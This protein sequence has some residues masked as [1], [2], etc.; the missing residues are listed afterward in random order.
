MVSEEIRQES[1][2]KS[3]GISFVT[4]VQL[5]TSVVSLIGGVISYFYIQ[6]DIP[7]HFDM[8]WKADGFAHRIFII[9]ISALPL[10]TILVRGTI[11]RRHKVQ[12]AKRGEYFACSICFYLFMLVQWFTIL[13]GLGVKTE[14]EMYMPLFG[15]IALFFIG[16]YMPVIRTNYLFGFRTPWALKNEICWRKT[17]RFGGYLMCLIAVVLIINAFVQLTI[18]T[19]LAGILLFGGL[20]VGCIYSRNVYLK[21]TAK[22]SQSK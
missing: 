1:Q 2:D 22:E 4:M 18:L 7:I 15:G 5:I 11:E 10:I 21:V 13:Y 17:N 3:G 19:A 16:N 20:A 14:Y 6:G 8:N 12:K 9:P